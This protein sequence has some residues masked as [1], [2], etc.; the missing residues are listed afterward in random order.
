VEESEREKK[1][2]MFTP[3]SVCVCICFQWCVCGTRLNLKPLFFQQQTPV[4]THCALIAVSVDSCI[5]VVL[6]ITYFV[7]GHLLFLSFF[8]SFSTYTVLFAR[9]T[10]SSRLINMVDSDV[11]MSDYIQS[12]GS[13]YE[14]T[15]VSTITPRM[16]H[17]TFH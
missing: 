1:K 15:P 9:V 12:S 7:V 13:D 17:L 10:R 4:I 3:N 6:D 11:D 2:K 5:I 14:E 8:H 16:L